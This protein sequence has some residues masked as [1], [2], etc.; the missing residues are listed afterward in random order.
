MFFSRGQVRP[1]YSIIVARS[2]VSFSC[3]AKSRE[4]SLKL[5]HLN[6]C[7]IWKGMN[8]WMNIQNNHVGANQ[9]AYH[10]RNGMKI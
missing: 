2:V 5:G 1:K 6:A 4:I 3:R 8:T 7:H 10:F 9:N